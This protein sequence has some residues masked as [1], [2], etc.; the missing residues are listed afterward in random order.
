L[1]DLP[2]RAQVALVT[3]DRAA[4]LRLRPRD[5]LCG[6]AFAAPCRTN[7]MQWR[8]LAI[9]FENGVR[10]FWRNHGEHFPERRVRTVSEAKSWVRERR[11]R[12]SR[13]KPLR[14]PRAR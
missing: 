2:G 4:A 12:R 10:G 7:S 6:N 14:P 5:V 13:P 8:K 1:P 3:G 11:V 9:L